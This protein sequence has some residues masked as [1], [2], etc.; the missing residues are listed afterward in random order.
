MKRLLM[1]FAF[2]L[3]VFPFIPSFAPAQDAGPSVFKHV[4]VIP[5]TGQTVL[6]DQDVVVEAGTI[7][8]VGP[9]GKVPSPP[10]ARI[11]DGR[12]RYLIPGLSDMHV[13]L[14]GDAW[15]L[16]YPAG[17]GFKESEINFEDILFVYVANGITTIDVLFAFP[18][19]LALRERIKNNE[20]PGPR[21]ILSR[22]IDG[23]GKAWPPPLGVWINNADEAEQ[24]VREAHRQGYDRIKVYSF[25]DQE[26]YDRIITTARSLGM[27]V[28]GHIP[29][30]TSVEHVISSGQ[31]MIAHV[32]E[33]MKFAAAYDSGQVAYF[34]DLLAGSNTWVTSALVLNRNLNALLKDSAGQFTKA[35]TEYLHPMARGLWA[36]VYQHVYKPIPEPHRQSMIDGYH[37]FQKPFVY[38]FHRK[39]GKLL[40]GTDALVPSTQPAFSL[41]DELEEL[42]DAGL[43]PLDVLKAATRNAHEF[44]GESEKA[45]TIEPGKAAD[46]VL[47]DE[48]PLENIA[49][50][51]GIRGVMIRNRWIPREEIDRRMGEIKASFA[52]LQQQ[53][54]R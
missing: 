30:A 21:L 14:E 47:L 41:H 29:F 15:N 2:I 31:R 40:V 3:T 42:V 9:A 10:G 11:I 45:G 19:H 39:G 38:A 17:E 53:R 44:L 6:T 33:V 1:L 13:H 32:E 46:L 7:R 25:L 12:G 18:E 20:F 35:N 54:L 22:M 26:S 16:M 8:H 37:G 4:N 52:K 43:S 34:S 23:A 24:A 5:M 36:Y 48:N 28:D 51:R 27:P 49:R 50:T